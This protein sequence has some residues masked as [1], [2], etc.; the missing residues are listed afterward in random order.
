MGANNFINLT[1]N[2]LRSTGEKVEIVA[3]NKVEDGERNAGDWVTY[4]DSKIGRASC[5]E[6]V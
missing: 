6:R 5:R 3:F 2:I 4:I 1:D